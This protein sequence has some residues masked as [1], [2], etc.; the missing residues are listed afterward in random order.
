MGLRDQ[1][2]FFQGR[3]KVHENSSC[4]CHLN[5]I[6]YYGHVCVTPFPLKQ[7]SDKEAFVKQSILLK[8][9]QNSMGFLRRSTIL[10]SVQL[11]SAK[12]REEKV[13]HFSARENVEILHRGQ[14]LWCDKSGNAVSAFAALAQM[15]SV[16]LCMRGFHSLCISISVREKSCI[17]TLTQ[18]I[19]IL[20]VEKKSVHFFFFYGENVLHQIVEERVRW[21]H[22]FLQLHKSTLVNVFGCDFCYPEFVSTLYKCH[23]LWTRVSP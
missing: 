4:G 6:P 21:K 10:H 20:P 1:E 9:S 13:L 19:E 5:N 17:L 23:L 14:E 3:G 11:L 8:P 22:G 12:T 7:S 16:C 2:F 15:N 18:E